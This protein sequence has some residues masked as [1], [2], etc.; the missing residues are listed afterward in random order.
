VA[1]KKEEEE[2]EE[3]RREVGWKAERSDQMRSERKEG[4]AVGRWRG[5]RRKKMASNVNEQTYK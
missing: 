2:K 1:G 3:R 5:R 4:G